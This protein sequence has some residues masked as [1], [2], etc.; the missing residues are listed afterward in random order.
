VPKLGTKGDDMDE[1]TRYKQAVKL[2]ADRAR[3]WRDFEPATPFIAYPTPAERIQQDLDRGAPSVVLAAASGFSD[4]SAGAAIL[5]LTVGAEY[6]ED[7]NND[8][9]NLLGTDEGCQQLGDEIEAQEARIIDWIKRLKE[10]SDRA[11]RL[12][13]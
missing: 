4:P 12:P 6:H 11:A 10:A 8:Y 7:T 13:G 2:A 3:E 9:H 5:R 1:D